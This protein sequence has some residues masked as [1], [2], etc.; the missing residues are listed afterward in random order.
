MSGWQIGWI[1]IASGL[2]VA[3][4][5]LS[6]YVLA[7]VGRILDR[8]GDI[9]VEAQTTL[10]RATDDALMPMAGEAVT[11]MSHVN[12]ELDKVDAITEHV[13]DVTRN[14]SALVAV[15]AATLGGPVVKAAAFSYGVRKAFSRRRGDEV[16]RRVR[17]ELKRER[18]GRGRRGGATR[19]GR[20]GA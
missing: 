10:K 16:E 7:R 2:T 14:V 19:A 17:A 1:I 3:L 18:S 15:F 8:I 11:T 20:R 5:V 9:V 4:I 13:H 12:A 6:V